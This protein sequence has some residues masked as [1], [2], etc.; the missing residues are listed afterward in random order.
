MVVDCLK[1][2]MEM[3]LQYLDVSALF[4]IAVEYLNRQPRVSTNLESVL[5]VVKLVHLLRREAPSVELEVLLYSGLSYRFRYH[6]PALLDAP[7][8]QNYISR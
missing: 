8:E 3:I 4:I 5:K 6:G 7:C 1:C 2:R